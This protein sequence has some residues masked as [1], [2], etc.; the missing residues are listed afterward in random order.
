MS[1]P[2]DRGQGHERPSAHVPI[3]ERKAPSPRRHSSRPVAKDQAAARDREPSAVR[4]DIRPSE[5]HAAVAGIKPGVVID[6]FR[7]P[8]SLEPTMPP[9]PSS[10]PRR[11]STL[12][13]LIRLGGA[14]AGATVVALLVVG[15]LPAWNA[16]TPD[17]LGEQATGAVGETA[18]EQVA[19][20]APAPSARTTPQLLVGPAAPG[21]VGDAIPLAISLV[22]A[23]NTDIVV[24]NGLPAGSNMTSG[25]PMG[26]SAWRLFAFELGN[27][28][29]RPAQGFLGGADLTVELRRGNRTVDHRT[30]HLEWTRSPRAATTAALVP[31]IIAASTRRL[32]PEEVSL[33][34]RRGEDLVANGDIAAAR[35]LLQRAA[36][37]EDPRAALALAASYDPVVLEQMRTQGL[38][39]NAGLARAWYERARQFGSAEASRRLDVQAASRDR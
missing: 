25:R 32:A 38:A 2:L 11:P 4:E 39:A 20:E 35:L 6:R 23:D 24:L 7:V 26:I 1:I 31:A 22:N 19:G 14:I 9:E 28:A 37:A 15:R 16:A 33:L 10:E 36:E 8:R 13:M 3:G 27:A 30:L 5:D 29:I 34:V 21:V 12:G 18:L 17:R